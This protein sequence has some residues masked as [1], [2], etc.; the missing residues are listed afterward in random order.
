MDQ[1]E[2]RMKPP[3]GRPLAQTCSQ[4]FQESRKGEAHVCGV[5]FIG[6]YGAVGFIAIRN[7]SFC[8]ENDLWSDLWSGLP[9]H[10]FRRRS[11]GFE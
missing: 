1:S 10:S 8:G 2:L 11:N 4:A 9:F 3:C 6:P 5:K 7:F